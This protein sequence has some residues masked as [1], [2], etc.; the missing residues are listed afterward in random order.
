MKEVTWAMTTRVDPKVDIEVVD[1][2]WATP[3]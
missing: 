1:G 2:C 3:P